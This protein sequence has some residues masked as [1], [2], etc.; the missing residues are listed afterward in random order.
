L[1][2]FATAGSEIKDMRALS[3]EVVDFFKKQSFVIVSTIDH[4]GGVNSSCKSIVKLDKSGRVY[5]LDL[6]LKHTFVNLKKNPRMNITAADEHSFQGYCLKGKARV[7]KI[8]QLPENIT[9]LWKEKVAVKISQRII[10]DLREEKSAGRHPEAA[11]PKPQY[12][13]VMEVEE[14]VDLTPRHL[15]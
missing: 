4:N 10:R 3:E 15:K 7:V 1:A 11:F 2:E 5:L 14:A 9:R 13:I 8:N 6:Y 12:M